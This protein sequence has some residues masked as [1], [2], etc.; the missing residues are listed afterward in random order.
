M[1]DTTTQIVPP[2]PPASRLALGG[3]ILG[4]AILV[5]IAGPALIVSSDLSAAWKTALSVGIFIVV[6]K[7]LIVTIV[8][9]LGKAGFAY[10]KSVCFRH[11]GRTLAPLAPARQVSK[12]RYRIGLVMF[13]LPLL[14]AWL[15]P[16]VETVFHEWAA[17][18]PIEWIWDVMLVASFFVLGG[19]FW[20][21]FRALFVH[22]ARAVFPGKEATVRA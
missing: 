4:L 6:P 5:K 22:G 13:I 17:A 21:K 1:T 9:I 10:L 14:N 15:V 7:L 20:D 2:P 18:R 8:F 11:V 19:D 16:Y 3:V 12:T